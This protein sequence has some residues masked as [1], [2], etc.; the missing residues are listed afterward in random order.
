MGKSIEKVRDFLNAVMDIGKSIVNIAK[1]ISFVA[2]VLIF[3]GAQ[4]NP[5]A[6]GKAINTI[7]L[8]VVNN[9]ENPLIQS[10]KKQGNIS[11]M[12]TALISEALTKSMIDIAEIFP[13]ANAEELKK[14]KSTLNTAQENLDKQA[15]AVNTIAKD[16]G[17][18]NVSP[19]KTGWVEIGLFG[20]NG[21]LRWTDNV[22]DQ[23]PWRN[24]NY[25]PKTITI[26]HDTKVTEDGDNCNAK[27]LENYQ[28][29]DEPILYT[30]IKSTP[31]PILVKKIASC[32]MRSGVSMYYAM[33]DIP[34]E[35]ARIS[36]IKKIR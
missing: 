4:I 36:S 25:P 8:E 16:S 31:E 18:L 1:G 29:S 15:A 20:E 5:S 7:G 26:T 12:Y 13:S 30:I 32:K 19:I 24:I 3:I 6:T 28:P 27:N 22:I 33:I 23:E 11:N 9:P 34:P 10:I 14:I 35:R 2:A 21:I 17:L